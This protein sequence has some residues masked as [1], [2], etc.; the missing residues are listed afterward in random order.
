MA[1]SYTGNKQIEKPANGDYP[2][3]WNVPVN[4]DWD[5][6]D[7]ALGSAVTKALTNLPV[8]LTREEAQN[9]QIVLTGTLTGNVQ[10]FLPLKILSASEAVGGSWIVYNNTSGSFTVTLFTAA[11]GSTGVILPQGRRSF[12]YSNGTDVSFADDVRLTEGTGIDIA[13]NGT[14]SLEVPVDVVNGGTG[15]TSLTANNLL[16]GNGTSD[17]TFIAPGASGN[18]LTSTGTTWTSQAPSGGSGTGTVTSVGMSGGTTG[19]S[20]LTGT[21][22]TFITNSGTFSMSGVLN[23]VNGGTG[24]NGTI[25]GFLYANGSGAM[26]ASTTINGAVVTGNIAGNALNV[27]GV[28]ALANG[29]TGA[30]TAAAAATALGLGTGS[31]PT[32][33][34]VNTTGR[35]T[36]NTVRV[37]SSATFDA[38][39]FAGGVVALNFSTTASLFGSGG[40]ME[41]Y[42]GSIPNFATTSTYFRLQSGITPQAFGT[43]AW[44]N[45]SDS[46]LKKNV[47]DYNFGLAELKQ[48]HTVTYQFNG[49]Y[50]TPN[51][52]KMNVGLIAQEVKNTAFSDMVSSWQHQNRE[53][54]EVTELFSV[55]TTPLVFA[56]INA[57][58][59]LSAEVEALKAKLP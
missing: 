23:P 24:S 38:M 35:A 52:G 14:I 9:Q 17:V 41:H 57:V 13:S 31:T 11:P 18:V 54:G 36:L 42:A 39:S 21:G 22:S 6:L 19:M 27:T 37:G 44:T 15:L 47:A 56:L 43:T 34:G 48:L 30:T 26:T 4:N 1:S 46:R 12:V 33:T 7:K 40:G 50:G 51:D 5:I 28:V 45:V 2:N 10:I 53:T 49:Q 16:V 8:N 58:K 29:G 55:N 32:F 3:T 20:F 59:E 25:T